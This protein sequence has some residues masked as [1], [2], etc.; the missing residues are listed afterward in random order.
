M[1]F[2]K[3]RWIDAQSWTAKQ[4]SGKHVAAYEN[5]IQVSSLPKEL[6]EVS[7]SK[8]SEITFYFIILKS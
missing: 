4:G 3:Q 2:K 6:H 5:Q 8:V 7:V 1:K